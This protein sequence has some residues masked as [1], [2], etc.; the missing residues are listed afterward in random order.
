MTAAVSCKAQHDSQLAPSSL[1]ADPWIVTDHLDPQR[2]SEN[3]RAI[4]RTDTAPERALRSALHRRGLRFRKDLRL[5]L[6]NG[7]VRPDIVFTRARVA[8][9][10][11]G[12][13]WHGCPEHGTQPQS[14]AEYWTPKLARNVARD[15]R[16]AAALGAAGWTVVRVWEHESVDEMLQSVESAVLGTA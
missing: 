16:N 13:F 2:R 10:V 1:L 6:S 3:M 4:K 9:F 15:Q 11:D 14:N 5:D 7:R 8:V 12:C